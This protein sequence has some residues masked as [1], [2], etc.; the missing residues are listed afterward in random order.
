MHITQ[1]VCAFVALGTQH[2]MRLRHIVICI[3]PALEYFYT[4]SNKRHDFLNKSL[5]IKCVFRVSLQRLSEIFLMLR[6]SEREMIENV[7][8]SSCE[9]HVILVQF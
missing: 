6:K 9:V 1:L 5:N 7:Y 2:A 4:L 3:L 8:W